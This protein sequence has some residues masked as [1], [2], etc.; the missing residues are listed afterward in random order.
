VKV[1]LALLGTLWPG[2]IVAFVI[3][4]DDPTDTTLA[5]AAIY[6]GLVATAAVLGSRVRRNPGGT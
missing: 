3:L 5:R 2:F 6:A 1:W 4:D